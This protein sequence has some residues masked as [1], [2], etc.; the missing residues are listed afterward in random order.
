MSNYRLTAI[1]FSCVQP[2]QALATSGGIVFF[3]LLSSSCCCSRLHSTCFLHR[4]GAF[5]SAGR[6]KKSGV[7]VLS[8]FCP[9]LPMPGKIYCLSRRT[10]CNGFRVWQRSS[11]PRLNRLVPIKL[12]ANF[13]RCLLVNDSLATFSRAMLHLMF[14][15]GSSCD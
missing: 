13:R 7:A 11:F 2:R 3:P 10:R 4:S 14:M 5:C 1:R 15:W 8:P 9:R 6:F 12:C